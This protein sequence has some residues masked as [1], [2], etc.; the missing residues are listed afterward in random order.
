M[1]L[2]Y[3]DSMGHRPP[4]LMEQVRDTIRIRHLSL[5]TET[6]YVRIIKDF[7]R[8]HKL[9]HPR[10]LGADDIR[11][12]LAYLARERNVA[13]S[14]QNAALS[15]LIFLYRFVLTIEL[16]PISDITWAQRPQHVPAVFTRDEVRR[17]LA[18]LVGI[19]HLMAS[20]LYG[21]G[22]RL[23]EVLRLRIKDID[24]TY[25]QITIHDAKG[26]KDRV[27]PLPD[28]CIE[29]L[30]EQIKAARAV[31]DADCKN[32]VHGVY[33]PYALGVK[34][35]NAATSF[36]WFWVFPTARLA[37]DPRSNIVRRHHLK[38]NALQRAVK[39]AIA[40]AGI[41]KHA[42]CHTFRHSFAT[43]LLE[44][45]AD[46]RTVQELLGHSDVKT[47]MI[48]THVLGKGAGAVRSPL[49]D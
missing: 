11:D 42:G 2:N 15:A 49:D 23:N 3:P 6:S 26:F 47:T 46:I 5:S 43:H 19:Y 14:T 28:A 20:L 13:A 16:P 7:I 41:N 29:P 32:K 10:E 12:Y 22:M 24:F 25:R 44:R 4:K 21:A 48:Y 37:Y 38:E 1:H 45:G 39:D 8:Y 17:V 34:L 9:T 30:R 27:V 31:Y 36:T 33:L 40:R 35:P 18:N